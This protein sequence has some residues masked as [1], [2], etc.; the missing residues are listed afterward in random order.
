MVLICRKEFS[1]LNYYVICI[2]YRPPK[3]YKTHYCRHTTFHSE[4]GVANSTFGY[5]QYNR[6]AAEIYAKDTAGVLLLTGKPSK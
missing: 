6:G 1:L 4:D 3:L 5:Q 2:N